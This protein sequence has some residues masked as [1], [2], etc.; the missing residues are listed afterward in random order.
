MVHILQPPYNVLASQK[1]RCHKSSMFFSPKRK[2]KL[3]AQNP[4]CLFCLFFLPSFLVVQEGHQD[5][6]EDDD[7]EEDDD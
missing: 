6:D 4:S 2:E 3:L 5:D 7:D 1:L